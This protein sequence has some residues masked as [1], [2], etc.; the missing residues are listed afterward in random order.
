[1]TIC[2][3]KIICSITFLVFIYSNVVAQLQFQNISFSEALRQATT[4]NRLIFLQFESEKCI[5]CNEVAN[6][7]FENAELALQLNE[8]FICIKIN[9]SHPDRLTTSNLLNANNNFGSFF[10]DK[11]KTLIHS[12]KK[13][14]TLAVHYKDQIGIALTKASEGI[15]ISEFENEYNNNKKNIFAL[16]AL[17]HKRKS[18]NLQTDSLLNDYINLI[19]KDSSISSSE[20]IFIAKMAPQLNSN[21]D[22][23]L[24]KNK[25]AFNNAW[26]SIPLSERIEIN[27][28]IIAKSMKK[29]VFEKNASFAYQVAAFNKSTYTDNAQAGEKA[30]DKNLVEYYF[31]TK[32]TFNYLIRAVNYYDKYYMTAQVHEILLQDSLR[33]NK[34]LEST[35][36]DTSSKTGTSYKITKS[37]A[38]SPQT[39]IFTQAL[40]TGAWNFYKMSSQPEYLDKALQWAK[41][42]VEFYESAEAMDTYARLLYKKGKKEDA[43]FWELKVISLRQKRGFPVIEFEEILNK[44]RAGEAKID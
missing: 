9:V 38:F 32:D 39:S 19:P 20:L 31:E 11:N 4:Q 17:L 6:K 2:M 3:K 44:M 24:R 25:I 15:R 14:S 40:N 18:L 13:S 22:I 36:G 8:T 37:F 1:M 34:I 21:P 33:R 27:G 5:Q 26:Y 35:K 41:R 12:F 16:Q 7:A 42:A 10:I 30:F 28:K 23:F 43:I 29:A